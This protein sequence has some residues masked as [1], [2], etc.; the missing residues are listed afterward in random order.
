MSCASFL[1]GGSFFRKIKKIQLDLP[2]KIQVPNIET[3]SFVSK[4]KYE[5]GQTDV[6]CAFTLLCFL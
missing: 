6:L 1:Y 5:D 4:V 2:V 3:C